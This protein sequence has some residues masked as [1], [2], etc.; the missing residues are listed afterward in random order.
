MATIQTGLD[1]LILDKTIQ[2][3][4]TG[5]IAYLCH[6]ASVD[7]NL[8]IGITC[9]MR[10][11]GKRLVKVFG[12]QHGL[13]SDVQDNMV[14]TDHYT[15]PYFKIPIYSLYSE[16][17]IPTDK[18][19]ED[20][21]TFIVDL[22]DVGTRV[23]TYISTMTLLMEACAK[24]DIKVVILDRPNP[25]GGEIVEGALL[26]PGFESFVGRHPIPQ[27]HGMTMAEMANYANRFHKIDCQLELI[28]MKGWQRSYFWNDC[29]RTWV[30]PSPN[31]ST[32]ESAITFCGTVLYEGTNLS[33]GRGTTRA[34]EVVGHPKIESYSFVDKIK[35]ELY[36]ASQGFVARPVVFMPTFQKHVGTAC[37]GVHLHPT[38]PDKF[39]SWRVGQILLRE[40]IST[41]GNAFQWNDKPYEYEHGRLAIDFIN[42]N[43]DLRHWAQSNGTL[44]ELIKIESQGM[45]E[46]MSHRADSLLY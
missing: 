23:Y 19:L 8:E 24:K 16:T 21:D 46:Y 13:V 15:H 43:E 3:K 37:G 28:T 26:S 39:L 22:Q 27:R 18:M 10:L 20:I 32:P 17:R 2:D 11:F 36:E 14:E 4:M 25:A 38:A 35:E 42:G 41:L 7:H 12:P 45:D 40:F 29:H 9:L 30:N 5:N 6:S 1:R 34:L 44:D 33:E 31:L